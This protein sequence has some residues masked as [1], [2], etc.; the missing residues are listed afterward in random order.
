MLVVTAKARLWQT[1]NT[2]KFADAA[3]VGNRRQEKLESSISM[4]SFEENMDETL[5]F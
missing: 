5:S 3:H 2:P 1:R 4:V